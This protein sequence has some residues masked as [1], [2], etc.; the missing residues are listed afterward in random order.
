[1]NKGWTQFA[2]AIV[3]MIGLVVITGIVV[4][5][6]ML[7]KVT[8]NGDMITGMLVGGLTGVTTMAAPWLFR[9]NGA[10]GGKS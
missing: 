2:V 7:G 4:T 6:Q 5:L 3:G 9:I 8:A 1:M 10:A